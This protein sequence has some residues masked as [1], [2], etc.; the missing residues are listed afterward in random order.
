MEAA[1][2]SLAYG[3]PLRFQ[4]EKPTRDLCL[5]RLILAALKTTTQK[6][7]GA[8]VVSASVLGWRFSTAESQTPGN[9]QQYSESFSGC[10]TRDNQSSATTIK[11]TEA[12]DVAVNS[13]D[14]I[15]EALKKNDP[16]SRSP[17]CQGKAQKP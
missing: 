13:L 1:A 11:Q 3:K 5:R 4:A 8:C 15:T 16:A 2:Q 14:R 6:Q 12:R 17:E 10:Y 7:E 9:F